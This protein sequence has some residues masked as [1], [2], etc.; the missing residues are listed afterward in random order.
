[1][2]SKT[3]EAN[4][5]KVMFLVSLIVL[6]VF[7]FVVDEFLTKLNDERIIENWAIGF[8]G[9]LGFVFLY[10]IDK[11]KLISHLMIEFFLTWLLADI[12]DCLEYWF[13]A[14]VLVLKLFGLS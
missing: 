8:W 11:V 13:N 12:V 3:P 14:L 10:I 1:M 7:F 5:Q 2:S 9:L 4:Q 6:T